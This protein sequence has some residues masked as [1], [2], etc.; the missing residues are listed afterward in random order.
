MILYNAL[1]SL[2]R[3]CIVIDI[4]VP[5]KEE[6]I[7]PLALGMIHYV[8]VFINLYKL[9]RLLL[10]QG[11]MLCYEYWII[12]V[13]Q[14]IFKD[15]NPCDWNHGITNHVIDNGFHSLFTILCSLIVGSISRIILN[16][17][18]IVQ[19]ASGFMIYVISTNIQ[20]HLFFI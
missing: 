1:I 7:Q 5:I 10:V 6:R 11:L 3:K 8:I 4:E 14:K 9:N 16:S 12:P 20:F 15:L 18:I 13:N 2:N 17:Y 19:V